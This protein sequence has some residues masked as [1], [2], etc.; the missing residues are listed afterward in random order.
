MSKSSGASDALFFVVLACLVIMSC[1]YDS[2]EEPQP[3]PLIQP[4]FCYGQT[5]TVNEGFY[6]GLHGK[7]VDVIDALDPPIKTPVKK[8]KILFMANSVRETP[9]SEYIRPELLEPFPEA[10]KLPAWK[11]EVEE[12]NNSILP[13]L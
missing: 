6:K 1:S 13:G 9:E 8:Y 4:A 2:K 11:P 10:I 5:V 3:V 7:V 12:S